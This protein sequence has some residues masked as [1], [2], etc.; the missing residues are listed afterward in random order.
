MKKQ[1]TSL[2]FRGTPEQEAQLKAL[3]EERKHIDG[4]LMQI[5][6]GA[7]EIYGYLPLE[8]QKMIAEGLGISIEEV[9]GVA[10]FYAQFALSPKGR[11]NICGGISVF[12]RN[13]YSHAYLPF[14][15]S[16]FCILRH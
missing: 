11:Y 1:P 4:C 12:W 6:Q 14:L 5:M 7:Q 2:P 15:T 3:I 8:V 10:T 13:L 9:Y 16:V